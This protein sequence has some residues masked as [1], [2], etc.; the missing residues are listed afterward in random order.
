MKKTVVFLTPKP[1]LLIQNEG[2]LSR[3]LF[4]NVTEGVLLCWLC[5]K[6]CWRLSALSEETQSLQLRQTHGEY[7]DQAAATN[8]DFQR[9][10]E[11]AERF[12]KHK[13]APQQ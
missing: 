5:E 6:L 12:Q 1:H 4:W 2:T 9:F 13:D 10:N 8:P 11:P 7:E 3:V